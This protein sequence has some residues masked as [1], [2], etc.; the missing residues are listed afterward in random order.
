MRSLR[1]NSRAPHQIVLHVSDGSD[2]TRAWAEAEELDYSHSVDNVGVCHGVN[3]A[4]RLAR[5]DHVL[6]MNDD[7]YACPGWDAPLLA[8]VEATGHRLFSLSATM[9]EPLGRNACAL[10]PEDF[11]RSA[12][13]FREAD[14]LAAAPRLRRPDWSG[15]S[16]PP[17]LVH[18]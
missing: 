3:A 6:Y 1:L 12:A 10:P 5:T 2:G 18:R 9:L 17:N 14:L 8:A 13:T 7:M 4:S 11:G 15:A 16:W